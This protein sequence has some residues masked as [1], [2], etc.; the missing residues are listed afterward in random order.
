[1]KNKEKVAGRGK[2]ITQMRGKSES[3]ERATGPDQGG[4]AK[5]EQTVGQFRVG[6]HREV[7][8]PKPTLKSPPLQEQLGT[9]PCPVASFPL[10]FQ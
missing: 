6:Q 5:D 7:L 4:G 1:M 10:G 2:E 9:I 3:S 8:K